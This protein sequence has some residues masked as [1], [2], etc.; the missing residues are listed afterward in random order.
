M[1]FNRIGK[2]V[3]HTSLSDYSHSKKQ[4]ATHLYELKRNPFH[5]QIHSPKTR[6]FG[7]WPNRTLL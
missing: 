3:L 2:I 5:I 7:L 6:P 4:S 1:V